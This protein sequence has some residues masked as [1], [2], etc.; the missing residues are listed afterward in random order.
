MSN[1]PK[2]ITPCPII[3]SGIEIRF[4]TK[5]VSN[6]INGMIYN[7]LQNSYNE[8]R[9]L[10]ILQLPIH[11]RRNDV[12]LI[13]QPHY[14][15]ISNNFILQIGDRVL[16]L[17]NPKIGEEYIGWNE[18][19][20]EIKN[21]LNIFDKLNIIDSVERIGVRYVDFFKEINIFDKITI[22]LTNPTGYKNEQ[23]Q[24]KNIFA[25]EDCKVILNIINNVYLKDN[26]GSLLDVD[27]FNEIVL[28]MNVNNIFDIIDNLHSLQKKIFFDILTKEYLSSLNP[29]Y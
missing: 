3:E 21:I 24:I 23:L 28:Q 15:L 18:Y 9:E 14:Q 2:L 26:K 19:S 12:N 20:N 10:P 6:I 11:I 5:L 7:E 29:E 22:S 27:A 13:Y 1:L 25:I 8:I 16:S 4:K 17:I